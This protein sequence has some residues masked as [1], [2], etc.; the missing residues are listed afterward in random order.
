[1]Y[2]LD[3]KPPPDEMKFRPPVA[4]LDPDTIT[5]H[6]IG[7]YRNIHI[8]T[9]V[10]KSVSDISLIRYWRGRYRWKLK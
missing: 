6:P 4:G 3:E 8:T 7:V 9:P 2:E 10:Q 5:Q 1:V